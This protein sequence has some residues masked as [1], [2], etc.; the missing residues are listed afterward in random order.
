MERNSEDKKDK[1]NRVLKFTKIFSIILIIWGSILAILSVLLVIFYIFLPESLVAAGSNKEEIID[2]LIFGI[3]GAIYGLV[4]GIG[5]YKLKKWAF[6]F[7][8]GLGVYYLLMGIF[9]F[10]ITLDISNI[11]IGDVVLGLC[12]IYLI[13]NRQYFFENEKV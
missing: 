1:K 7:V 5:L 4:G 6:Y 8:C 10:L 9:Y 13:R 12:S 11:G 2:L 3:P